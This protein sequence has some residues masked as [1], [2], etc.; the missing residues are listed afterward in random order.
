MQ[1]RA[2]RG[3]SAACL[4][5]TGLV[6]V[7]LG[8]SDVAS[9]PMPFEFGPDWRFVPPSELLPPTDRGRDGAEL[10]SY[11]PARRPERRPEA[12]APRESPQS[13]AARRAEALQKAMA[14]R[15]DPA[16]LRREKLDKLLA[17]LAVERDTDRAARL[18][19]TIEGVWLESGSET[20]D[21]LMQ[22]ALAA[23]TT[24]QVPL[25]LELLDR[26]VHLEPGW[27]E[28]WNRR[29]I[30]RVRAGDMDGAMAD[31]DHALKLEPRHFGA[32]ATMGTILEQTGFEERALEVFRRAQ[33]IFPLLPLLQDH[34]DRLV[35][36][37]EGRAI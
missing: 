29:A 32:L 8:G 10:R 21:L 31:I 14:P 34:I 20:A 30:V 33:G 7:V 24:A 27:V 11:P 36:E 6:H 35:I 18:A 25:A 28:A 26:I 16:V 37:V 17:R 19:E 5:V 13:E 15:P 12:L 3:L 22:R 1:G 4:C 23:L 2:I 9:Q